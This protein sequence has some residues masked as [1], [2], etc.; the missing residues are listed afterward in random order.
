MTPRQILYTILLVLSVITLFVLY[1]NQKNKA[2]TEQLNLVSALQDTLHHYQNNDSSTN[3][4][5]ESLQS[6][7]AQMF[8]QNEYQDSILKSLRVLI[9]KEQ[10][11]NLVLV[12]IIKSTTD[13]HSKLPNDTPIYYNPDYP[14]YV[15][16]ITKFGKWITGRISA[17]IDST[18]I[19]IQILNDYNV[20]ISKDKKTSKVYADVTT[21]N[22]YDKI[23]TLRT[24]NITNNIQQSKWGIDYYIGAGI[25]IPKFTPGIQ[26][27]IGISKRL[28]N[29]K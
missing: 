25:A 3:Y 7:N 13:I 22:P 1:D 24:W 6:E 11:K 26:I 29:F 21:L 17:S 27:G 12:G 5:I 9:V 8:I 15:T 16:N 19:D 28:I 2:I 20:V 23:G 14:T 18:D 4:E 10:K